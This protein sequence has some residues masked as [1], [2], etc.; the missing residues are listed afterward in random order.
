MLTYLITTKNAFST[1]SLIGLIEGRCVTGLCCG[2]VSFISLAAI[3]FTYNCRKL[4]V[5]LFINFSYDIKLV[6]FQSQ[7][8]DEDISSAELF[9]CLIALLASLLK[10][11][12]L[13]VFE[14]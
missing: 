13:C 3:I 14:H 4:S 8:G 10:K 6:G 12:V 11:I 5:L 1:L 7:V 9:W 2:R